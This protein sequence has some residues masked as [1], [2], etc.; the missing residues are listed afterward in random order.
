MEEQAA[1]APGHPD[2]LQIPPTEMTAK[3]KEQNNKRNVQTSLFIFPKKRQEE[4][5]PLC[6]VHIVIRDGPR[7]GCPKVAGRP[8]KMVKYAF[9][10]E[11]RPSRATTWTEGKL[12]DTLDFFL[13]TTSLQIQHW[14]ARGKHNNQDKS[15]HSAPWENSQVRPQIIGQ[16]LQ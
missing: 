7:R 8:P 16:C 5:D 11:I 2:C 10:G 4:W 9:L 12:I 6:R 14:L 13:K 15:H 3:G 1:I